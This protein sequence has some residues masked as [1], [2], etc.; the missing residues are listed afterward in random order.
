MTLPG[1]FT[2]GFSGIVVDGFGYPLFFVGTGV[3]GIPAI[4]MVLYLIQRTREA[5][6][7]HR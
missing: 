6:L 5:S 1:K 4:V 7:D 2:S 3:L